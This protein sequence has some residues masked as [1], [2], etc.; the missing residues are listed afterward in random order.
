MKISGVYK[1][2]N[3][4]TGEF[5]IGSSRNIMLRW[6][7]HKSPSTWK[8]CLN[9]RLYQDMEKYGKS[10]FALEIVEE[11]NS[12]RERE[13]YF[14]GLLQPTYN[15]IRASGHD[16]DKY[17]SSRRKYQKSEKGKNTKKDYNN[18]LCEY[19]G[20]TLTLAALNCRFRRRNIPNA[21]QEAKKYLIEDTFVR[22]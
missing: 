21:L 19:N 8:E 20:K 11:T 3:T 2:T 17:K 16:L 9:S 7:I 6:A 15:T 22:V 4:V 18:R 13:Q 12:L 14:I 1:I 5:Y 10:Q